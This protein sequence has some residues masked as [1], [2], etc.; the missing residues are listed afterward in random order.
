MDFDLEWGCSGPV[1]RILEEVTLSSWE[2][3]WCTGACRQGDCGTVG[4]GGVG[5]LTQV[6]YRYVR[7]A[8]ASSQD[9]AMGTECTHGWADW[10]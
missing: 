3:A 8:K 7:C 5:M 10:G 2:G 6:C 9:G 1:G 4:E